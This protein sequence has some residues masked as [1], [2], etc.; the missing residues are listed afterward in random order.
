MPQTAAAA[1]ARAEEEAEGG[2]AEADKAEA[3]YGR[4]RTRRKRWKHLGGSNKIPKSIGAVQR[5]PRERDS[6]LHALIHVEQHGAKVHVDLE[7]VR[8]LLISHLPRA[9]AAL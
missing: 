3:D 4:R 6:T 1:R 7:R 2:A 8:R 5:L 9:E